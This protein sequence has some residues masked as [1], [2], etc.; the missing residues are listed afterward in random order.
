MERMLAGTR[1]VRNELL[2]DVMPDYRYL[3]HRGLS[4]PR[5][6]VRGMQEFNGSKPEFVVGQERLTVVLR[7][8]PE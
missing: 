4:V 8:E 3:E 5:K 1:A 6:I 7:R 2:K